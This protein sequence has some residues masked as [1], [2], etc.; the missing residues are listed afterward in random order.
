[1]VP[2]AECAV[3]SPFLFG[4]ERRRLLKNPLAVILMGFQKGAK[5]NTSVQSAIVNQP[6]LDLNRHYLIY[7]L[8]VKMRK[9]ISQPNGNK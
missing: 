1:M 7:L 4:L 3:S 9:L 6:L 2:V 5:P 8:L